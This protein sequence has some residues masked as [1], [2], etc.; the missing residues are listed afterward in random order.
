METSDTQNTLQKQSPPHTGE[1][2]NITNYTL[3]T[4]ETQNTLER[5]SPTH[6]HTGA[7]VTCTHWSDCNNTLLRDCQQ[8]VL[9]IKARGHQN[10]HSTLRTE[11]PSSTHWRDH[12]QH[13]KDEETPSK[14]TGD[15]LC[16]CV[17][18]RVCVC[19]CVRV[20]VDTH[21]LFSTYSQRS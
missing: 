10:T 18:V 17:W 11:G 8:T 6:T 9:H 2:V 4:S 1:T 5:P 7:N 21:M 3:E 19:V 14:H 12:E 20:C 15:C 16:V 13:T